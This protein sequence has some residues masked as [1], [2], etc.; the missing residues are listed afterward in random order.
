MWIICKSKTQIDHCIKLVL[1]PLSHH[2]VNKHE[3]T[4]EI[5]NAITT[6]KTLKN[7]HFISVMRAERLKMY[8]FTLKKLCG[9][10]TVNRFATAHYAY[11]WP[12]ANTATPGQRADSIGCGNENPELS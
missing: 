10:R 1:N 9:R 2:D 5:Q 6:I 8:I 3:I 7:E 12:Y 4:A 11:T